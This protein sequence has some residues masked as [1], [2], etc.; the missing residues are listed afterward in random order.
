[1]GVI[2]S[3]KKTPNI[4]GNSLFP[5]GYSIHEC[6][7]ICQVP[8]ICI[9]DNAQNAKHKIRYILKGSDDGV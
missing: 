2:I 6:K 1:M 5:H 8:N 7:V 3:K 4:F 9:T